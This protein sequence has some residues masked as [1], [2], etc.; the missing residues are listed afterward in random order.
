MNVIVGPNGYGV[1]VV[2]WYDNEWGYPARLGDLAEL[3][4][5]NVRG[6]AR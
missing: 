2:D 5:A 3:L 4:P 6:D 1:K